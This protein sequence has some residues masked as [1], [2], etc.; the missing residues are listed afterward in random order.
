[1]G[2]RLITAAVLIAVSVLALW[3]RTFDNLWF[4]IYINLA[5]V[6]V[7]YEM[8]HNLRAELPLPVRVILLLFS[9]STYVVFR[10]LGGFSA[11]VLAAMLVFLVC[12]VVLVFLPGATRQGVSAAAL[13]LVYPILLLSVVYEINVRE[14]GLFYIV[15]LLAVSCL[16]DSMAYF[17]GRLCKG[18]KLC[19]AVSPNKTISGAVGGLVGGILAAVCCYY[20]F[21]NVFP[22]YPVYPIWQLLIAGFVGAAFT[23]V[24]DLAESFL[25]RQLGI[26]DFSNLLPG[27]GGVLDRLDGMLFCNFF[28]YF[29]FFVILV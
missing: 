27:H 19:P 8:T 29:Y 7:V 5:C 17:V 28:L 10:F 22:D 21:L 11:L 16:A 14:N 18:P 20:F 4:A 6:A 3:L 23:E 26:K 24:G 13:V 12:F 9:A 2:K 25:K 15:F 1:M